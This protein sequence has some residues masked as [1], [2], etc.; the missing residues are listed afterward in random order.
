MR[1]RELRPWNVK[2]GMYMRIGVLPMGGSSESSALVEVLDVEKTRGKVT[3][4][5]C[6]RITFKL[7]AGFPPFT[8]KPQSVIRFPDERITVEARS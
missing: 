2:P 8:G 4:K 5:R 7:G 1:A 3:G 6:W